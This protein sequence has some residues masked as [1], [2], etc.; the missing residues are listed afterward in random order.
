MYLEI[1]LNIFF[2]RSNFLL[3]A[4]AMKFSAEGSELSEVED[5]TPCDSSDFSQH[6]RVREFFR[7]LKSDFESIYGLNIDDATEILKVC[8]NCILALHDKKELLHQFRSKNFQKYDIDVSKYEVGNLTPELSGESGPHD[9]KTLLQSGINHL[10]LE[11]EQYNEKENEHDDYIVYTKKK[12]NDKRFLKKASPIADSNPPYIPIEVLLRDN[13]SPIVKNDTKTKFQESLDSEYFSTMR[14]RLRLLV[15][16]FNLI[17]PPSLSISQ[18][19][20]RIRT[21]SSSATTV[22]FVNA[23]YLAFKLCIMLDLAPITELNCHR[24]VLALIRCLMKMLE[25]KRQ[26]Q[27]A[28]A[29]VGGLSCGDLESIEVAFLYLCDFNMHVTPEQLR[30]FLSYDFLDMLKFCYDNGLHIYD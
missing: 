5:S 16:V 7:L 29:A 11:E 12:P 27:K 18:Y 9:F 20:V 14:N 8:F 21:Y 6:K 4:F 15:K 22:V 1:I 17:R 26:K 2:L 23:A 19:I 3:E 13:P 10:S 28:F 25:D 24:F 30:D